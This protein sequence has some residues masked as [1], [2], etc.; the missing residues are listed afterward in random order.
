MDAT[1][2]QI[3]GVEFPVLVGGSSIDFI[4]T[5]LGNVHGH[6]AAIFTVGN[7]ELPGIL[8]PGGNLVGAGGIGKEFHSCACILVIGQSFTEGIIEIIG[9]QGR[10]LGGDGGQGGNDLVFHG[11]ACRT[12]SGVGVAVGTGG[13][14]PGL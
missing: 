6:M 12:G 1:A 7:G 3:A 11:V 5:G 9:G 4:Q 14:T 10:C 13:N 2:F 8:A